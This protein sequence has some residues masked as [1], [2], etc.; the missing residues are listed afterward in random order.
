M[1]LC[2]AAE[3]EYGEK[4]AIVLCRD[5]QA[6]KGLVTSDDADKQRSIEE[7][8]LSC[9]ILIAGHPTRADHLLE[10]CEKSIREFMRKTDPE[11]TDLDTDALLQKLKVAAKVVRREMVNDWVAKTQNMEFEDFLKHGKNHYLESHYHDVWNTIQR[12]DMQAELLITLFDADRRPVIIRT[13]GL[14]DVFFENNYGIIGT[15]GGIARAFLCQV[16]YDPLE[17]SVG[18]CIYECLRAKFSAERGRDVG[19]ST[20]VS[21]S[22]EGKESYSWSKKGHKYWAGKLLPYKTPKLIFDPSFLERDDADVPS[23]DEP[24][25]SSSDT[26]VPSPQQAG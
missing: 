13:D 10:A 24:K 16:D 17:M 20:T 11:N 14:A 25:G 21:V 7:S 26:G 9:E 5:W 18:D 4:S 1:T 8:G 22:V 15:G 19:R 6:Q 23:K 2:I 3:C 12:Y